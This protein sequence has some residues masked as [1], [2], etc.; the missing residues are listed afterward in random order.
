MDPHGQGPVQIQLNATAAQL[1]LKLCGELGTD[2]PSSVMM[3][4]LGL[5]EMAQRTKRTGG[6]IF[7]RNEHGHEAE[8]VF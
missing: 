4:A 2:N 8:V 5:L 6:S 1:L 3:R 7:F